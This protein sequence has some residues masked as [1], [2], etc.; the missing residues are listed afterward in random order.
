MH[1][2]LRIRW[3]SL[4]SLAVAAL[5]SLLIIGACGI[6]DLRAQP[7][8][9][10]SLTVSEPI[11]LGDTEDEDEDLSHVADVGGGDGL[12]GMGSLGVSF[13]AMKYFSGNELSDGAVRPIFHGQFKYVLNDHLVLP[14]E[15]GWGW[16]A[17]GPGGGYDGPDSLGTL[18][19]ATPVTLGLDYRFQTGKPSVVPRVGAGVGFYLLSIRAGRS[20]PSRDPIS[21][22]KRKSTSL[23]FYGKLGV[24]FMLKPTLWLNTD[25]LVH[26]ILSADADGYPR[27]WLDDNAGFAEIRV[28]LNHYFSIRGGGA[29]VRGGSGEEEEE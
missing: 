26:E 16:N 6:R 9:A 3:A 28:G 14:L 20:Q 8:P 27:G 21:D 18:A 2:R 10:D 11:D 7:P 5:L 29:S 4:S 23:G 13:G 15:G 12:A 17:Y 25:L 24:E 22:R 19:V 1:F